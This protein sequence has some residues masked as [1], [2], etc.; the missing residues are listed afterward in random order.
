LATD[1][2]LI[3]IVGIEDPL[4]EGVQG[5]VA[6]C[7]QAGV[8]VMMCTGDNLLTALSIAQQ[9]GIYT[10]GGIVMNGPSFCALSADDVKAIAPRLQVLARCTPEDKRVLVEMLKELGETVCVAGDGTNDGP[11]LDAA[12]VGLTLGIAGTEVA[13]EA[14][15]VVLMDD[16]FPSI[17]NVIVEG[18][19]LNEFTRKLLQFQIPAKVAI[20]I[21]T[22]VSPLLP[23]PVLSA[24][25]LL[26]VLT[27]VDGFAP[28]AL[29]TEPATPT[30]LKPRQAKT[31]SPFTV[32]MT[33]HVLGQSTYQIAIL[34]LLP[35]FLSRIPG[36]QDIDDPGPCNSPSYATRALVFNTF[37]F[38]QI[39]NTL[40]S[41]HLDGK[42]NAFEGVSSNWRF[43]LIASVG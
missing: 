25:Q 2:T 43:M 11:A 7:N 26:W 9:C 37:V 14:S 40:N 5:A 42:L 30:W 10:P 29:A 32:N 17:V 3:G 39:S 15:D 28:L 34:L 8:R 21:A 27:I 35:L 31:S 19:R 12:H 41:R 6:N 1:L 20:I 18:R 36:H 4:R 23:S 24:A 16:H 22:L 13:E 38:A 33:K